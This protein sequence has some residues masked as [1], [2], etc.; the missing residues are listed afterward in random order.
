MLTAE[1][2]RRRRQRLWERLDPKP[3]SDH[4]RLH[5]PIHLEYFANFHVDPFSLGAG[6]DGVLLVRNDGHAKL[7]YDNRLPQSAAEPAHVDDRAMVLW[8]DGQSPGRGPR[9]LAL[10][11]GVNPAHGGLRIHDRLGDPY[12]ATLIATVAEMRRVKDPD[13]VALLKQCMRATEA[14]H[15]WARANIKPGLTELQVYEGVF[16]AC[17]EAA[18][19]P[20]IVYGDFAVSPGPERRGGPPTE[21]VLL[22]GDLFILD[23]SVVLRGYRSDFTNT[24]VVGREPTA[25]QRRLYDLC[26]AAMAAGE[27]ELRAGAACRTVYDAVRDTFDRAGVA[28]HFP[29]HAGHGL[30]LSHPEAPF[31]VREATETL[32][33]GDVV[34]LEPGL[35]IS[36]VGGLR[37]EHNYLITDA[38]Y[39]RLSNHVITLK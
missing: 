5:D 8:Y 18:K 24:L 3:D 22:P 15:A 6:F 21:R 20:V 12:A 30:G 27:R 31:F 19:Q 39:E 26:V 34:T 23:F 33:A 29:H 38:G 35:Y 16:A 13:E 32:L 17:A 37:I 14:G 2:C 7:L 25:D 1:G 28:K 11:Q 10:L 9:Q 36:G 4:V